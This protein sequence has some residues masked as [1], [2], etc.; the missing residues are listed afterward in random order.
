MGDGAHANYY[1]PG[2]YW[3]V[4]SST[5]YIQGKYS[6]LPTT[7][8]LSVTKAIAIGGPFLKGH[9]LIIQTMEQAAVV[10]YDGQPLITSFPAT[11][12][13]ID[14]L[15]NIQYNSAGSLLDSGKSLRGQVRQVP[16]M[17]VLHITLP[18]G[19]NLEVNEWN[20][21]GEG[22]YMNIRI[23]MSAQPGQDGHCGNFNGNAADDARMQVRARVGTQ[24][25]PAGPQFLFPGGKTPVNPGKHPDLNDCPQ[26]T[27]TRAKT[28]CDNAGETSMGCML[29]YCFVGGA[30][31]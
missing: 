16:Q 24:G 29:D 19:I 6:A 4:K 5:V 3:I 7:N 30:A 11:S 2:E 10:T 15:V 14:G 26:D 23:T 20:E 31:R 18:L 27:M 25:V 28:A 8:G 13:S 17:H 9:K 12:K 21:P 22:P 1:T